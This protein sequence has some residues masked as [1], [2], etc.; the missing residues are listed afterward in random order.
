MGLLERFLKKKEAFDTW[1]VRHFPDFWD[2]LSGSL[3][4]YI[5]YALGSQGGWGSAS[6]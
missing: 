2:F 4:I 6:A 5:A 1:S 3:C